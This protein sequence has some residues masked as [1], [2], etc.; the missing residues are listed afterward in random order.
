VVEKKISVE[1]SMKKILLVCLF[2]TGCAVG[3]DYKR[4]EADI[5]M[6]F[7][8]MQGW[9]A[10]TPS[11]ALPRGSWWAMFGDA[12]LDALMARVEV[13]NQTIRAAEARFR[14]ARALSDQARSGLFP[15]VSANGAVTRSKQPS[16]PNAPSATG[17]VTNYS[18]SLNASWE[19]DLWGGV[20]RAVEAGDA[21]WQASAGELEAARLSAR[22][23]LAQSYFALRVA[24]SNRQL[25]EDTVAAYA[26]TLE[27]TRNRYTAGVV[28]RVDVVQAE[29]QWKSAQAQLID[30]AVERGQLEHAIAL[31]AGEAPANFAVERGPLALAM[32]QIPVGVPAEL[33]ERRPDVAS[34]ERNVA[35]A[36][37][38]IGVAKAAYFPAL[39]LSGAVGY[40]STDLADL[41][42]LPSRFWSIGGSIAQALFDAGLRKAQSAQ[43]IAAYDEQ[44]ANYR[45]TVL[46]GLQEVEDNLVAL[47][48]L[49]DEA[50]IQDE[51]VQAARQAVELTTNQYRAGVVSYLNVIQAQATQLANERT[52]AG[53]LGRRLTASV[54][55]VRALGGGWTAEALP[56]R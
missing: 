32:P 35:A 15:S 12:E 41:F 10:A 9:R 38:R 25:L 34:A 43:A 27:M 37:A 33:L 4:P 8:E 23:A 18:A 22:A 46:T 56:Q 24:D 14:Q 53:I 29:V 11:D 21:G 54:G 7:K 44:V 13:S 2:I 20:R 31:L 1:N 45:Q 39:T 40:R 36:N 55:L 50:R 26:R 17:A 30:L 42:T 16:L 52:A 6:Q 48:V 3:P 51:V 28:A 47:R 5:P 49:E 19:P